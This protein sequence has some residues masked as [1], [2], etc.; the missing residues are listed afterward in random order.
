[1]TF[2]DE[3]SAEEQQRLLFEKK[4]YSLSNGIPAVYEPI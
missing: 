4:G 3:I 2:P 1:M